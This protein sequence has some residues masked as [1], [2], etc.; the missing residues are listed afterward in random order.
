L[1]VVSGNNIEG[2]NRN[3]G[4]ATPCELLDFVDS[5]FPAAPSARLAAGSISLPRSVYYVHTFSHM[6]Y[7]RP[8]IDYVSSEREAGKR[9]VCVWGGRSKSA[10]AIE[11]YDVPFFISFIK[12]I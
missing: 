4:T 6:N 2:E 8:A 3:K 11:I 5:A 10:L 12:R 9:C 7:T 1:F